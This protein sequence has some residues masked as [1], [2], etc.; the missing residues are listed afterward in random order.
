MSKE[1]TEKED[2]AEVYYKALRTALENGAKYKDL[3]KIDPKDFNLP[4]TWGSFFGRPA[5]KENSILKAI[6]K[7]YLLIESIV[8]HPSLRDIAEDLE[9]PYSVIM[10][11]KNM[12]K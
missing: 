9:A 11:A 6:S 1:I 2:R 4:E 12:V 10:E 5:N 7:E 3:L 8:I